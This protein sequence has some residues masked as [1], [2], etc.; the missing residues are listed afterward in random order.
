[1]NLGTCLADTFDIWCI[2]QGSIIL[3]TVGIYDTDIHIVES[4]GLIRPELHVRFK[5]ASD[6]KQ[7]SRQ[8]VL[9]AY[10]YLTEDH[11]AFLAECTF[12][13]LYRLVTHS[14]QRR[15]QTCN[16]SNYNDQEQND[17]NG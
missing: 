16:A 3:F 5:A 8:G 9:D 14:H 15:R 13:Y 2:H 4:H 11:L 17:D 7:G 12:C 6:Y 10:E 1:M